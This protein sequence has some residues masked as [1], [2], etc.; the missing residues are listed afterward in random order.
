MTARSL[1]F[2]KVP[3]K[4]RLRHDIARF[5]RTATPEELARYEL[6]RIPLVRWWT[7]PAEGDG[8]CGNMAQ[9]GSLCLGL[10]FKEIRSMWRHKNHPLA[11]PRFHGKVRFIICEYHWKALANEVAETGTSETVPEW[12]PADGTEV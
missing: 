2:H 6:H 8:E 5:K 10:P 9:D 7:V 3:E 1:T 11:H 4:K 12:V